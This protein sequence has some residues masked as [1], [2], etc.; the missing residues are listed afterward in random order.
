MLTTLVLRELEAA[1][2]KREAVGRITMRKTVI[3]D[4][5]MAVQPVAVQA[6][7]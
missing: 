2:R 7:G 3:S 5:V 1:M 6:S 4:G